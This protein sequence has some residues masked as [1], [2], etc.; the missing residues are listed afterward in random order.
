[1][2]TEGGS[3]AEVTAFFDASEYIINPIDPI[4]IGKNT[5][6]LDSEHSSFEQGGAEAAALP[7]NLESKR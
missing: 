4:T 7:H 5:A 2:R 6:R 1:M 3:I